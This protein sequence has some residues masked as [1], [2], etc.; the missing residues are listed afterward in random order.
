MVLWWWLS[1]YIIISSSPAT[2][3]P[4]EPV[5]LRVLAREVAR[6]PL[7]PRPCCGGLVPGLGPRH[8]GARLRPRGRLGGGQRGLA[9]LGAA[10][11][12]HD[13]GRVNTILFQLTDMS[14]KNCFN[15]FMVKTTLT[16]R[17]VHHVHDRVRGVAPR[18]LPA[19][20]LGHGTRGQSTVRHV[21]LG[22]NPRRACR[23]PWSAPRSGPP[24]S[25]PC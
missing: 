17:V 18:V 19:I 7:W 16:H 9:R 13:L 1:S 20:D 25:A 10:R 6:L 8:R 14:H 5:L 15:K 21:S 3:H 11:R 4:P 12:V 23:T 22:C 24:S 2:S